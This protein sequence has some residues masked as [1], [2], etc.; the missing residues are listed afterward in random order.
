MQIQSC[1]IIIFVFIIIIISMSHLSLHEIKNLP[2]AYIVQN[3]QWIQLYILCS[4]L[5]LLRY[6][7]NMKQNEIH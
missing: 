6:N 3:L 2:T 5:K 1:F 7:D 4:L